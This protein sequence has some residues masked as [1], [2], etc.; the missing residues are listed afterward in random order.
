MNRTVRTISLAAVL[1][2]APA[3]CSLFTPANLKS[4]IDATQLA[5]VFASALTDS[6]AVADACQIDRSL[7]PVLD[8]LIAQREGAK[9]SG[10]RWGA[11]AGAP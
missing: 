3:A 10:V 5:C 2:V 6:A 11:D 1:L 4:A 7:V 8:Q 9:K